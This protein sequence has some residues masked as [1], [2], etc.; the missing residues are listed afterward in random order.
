MSAVM[1]LL[2]VMFSKLYSVLYRIG[3]Y[4]RVNLIDPLASEHDRRGAGQFL[5]EGLAPT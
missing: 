5:R 2:F 4:R 3:L 1:R